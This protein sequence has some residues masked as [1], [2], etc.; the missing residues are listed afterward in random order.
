MKGKISTK[1]FINASGYL[2]EQDQL[3]VLPGDAIL[4]LP[5]GAHIVDYLNCNPRFKGVGPATSDKL[6]KTF[7]DHLVEKLD[8]GDRASLERVVSQ[9]KALALVR[10]WQAE[11]LD[12]VIQWLGANGLE[13]AVSRRIV[14]HFGAEAEDKIHE[15]PYR[16]L[17]FA[18]GW[19][20]VDVFA[21][22]KLGVARTDDR[23]L[24]AAVEECVYR[25]FNRGDT[26]VPLPDL[27]RGIRRL[28]TA[29]NTQQH[30]ID[31]A[32][33]FCERA[34]RL[35]FDRQ[36]NAYSPGASVL[37]DRV[38]KCIVSRQGH[39]SPAFNVD[40]LINGY[41]TREGNGCPLNSEQRAAVHLVADHHFA[42]ITGGAGC[43]KTTV[44]KAACL[45]LEAQ[46][47]KIIQVAAAG[48]ATRGMQE[49]T[50]RAVQTI[51]SLLQDVTEGMV[52]D[53]S[54]PAIGHAILVFEADKVDLITFSALVRELPHTVKLVLIGDPH[55]LPPV[56]PGLI[57]HSLTNGIVPHVELKVAKG[58]ESEIS[59]FA[60][61]I[62]NG[63]FPELHAN[64]PVRFTEIC[65]SEMA[66]FAFKEYLSSPMDTVVLC[67]TRALAKNIN[68]RVQD[69]LT[70]SRS[71]VMFRSK[72]TDFWA[73]TRLREGDQ[74]I[75]TRNNWHLGL[76]HG[77]MGRIVSVDHHDGD[78][79]GKIE[80]DD[81]IVRSFNETL[82]DDLK[83]AYA[84]TVH[85]CQGA[86]WKRVLVCLPKR[87]KVADQT[88][89]YTAV[90]RA[91]SEVLVL[92]NRLAIQ[93]QVG[94][95]L[96]INQRFVGLSKRL[97]VTK[98][99]A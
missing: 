92:G 66:E 30:V 75:C 19:R 29:E 88:L 62:R 51:A 72:E 74:V 57:L 71:E 12:K 80:W 59:N 36:E 35:F 95:N 31:A 4:T 8:A 77:S 98:L 86:Q 65:D 32:L 43:G 17:S 22:Q 97:E 47:Y 20:E 94:R 26:C 60:N 11:R 14:A 85:E 49:S 46:G 93:E 9:S 78:Q 73:A 50:G 91:Q 15:N 81:G 25:R 34:G 82:L 76:Q 83:P 23:R 18:A 90:T 1:R 39:L 28:L 44:L 55:Q 33:G 40:E 64:G 63:V 7:G 21:T 89:V 10:G 3:E 2:T 27:I 6:W 84:L 41:E 56:G 58:Y 67:S 68:Q 13:P 99:S 48:K 42:V 70:S 45:V 96:F 16:I 61:S 79:I 24:S 53:S 87:N 37:E 54:G 69:A 5:L 52:I 38:V